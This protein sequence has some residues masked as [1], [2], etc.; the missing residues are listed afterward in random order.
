MQLLV[1]IKEKQWENLAHCTNLKDKVY[2]SFTR[3]LSS[4][5]FSIGAHSIVWNVIQKKVS[6]MGLYKSLL[7]Q[8]FGVYDE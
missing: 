1:P 6:K 3:S 4:H 8:P 5:E 2:A 7:L